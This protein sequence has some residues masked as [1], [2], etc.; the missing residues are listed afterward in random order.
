MRRAHRNRPL[1]VAIYLNA[2]L[3]LAVL[4][5]LLSQGRGL[6]LVPSAYGAPLSPQPIAGGANLYLMPAQ[7]TQSSWGCY[8]MDI[9]S[10]TL[11]A[12]QYHHTNDGTDLQLVAARKIAYDTKLTNF[13]SSRPSPNEVKQWIEQA[14]HGIRGQ[15]DAIGNG[16]DVPRSSTQETTPQ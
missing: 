13:N 6:S 10:K 1:L 9:D 8:V 16:R 4:V 14:S 12:Y 11:C 7:F 5:A 3:M 2:V 15:D